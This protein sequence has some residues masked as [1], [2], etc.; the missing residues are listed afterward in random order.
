M[1]LI[2]AALLAG[3]LLAAIECVF[4]I[5]TCG[6]F[7]VGPILFF[8]TWA[9]YSAAALI[10]LLPLHLLL[11]GRRA[12]KDPDAGGRSTAVQV[13]LITLLGCAALL[14]LIRRDLTYG[15]AWIT[16]LVIMAVAGLVTAAA[17]WLINRGRAASVGRTVTLALV[18]MALLHLFHA[19]A[20]HQAGSALEARTA[21]YDGTVPHLCLSV[22]DTVRGDH[23]SCVGYPWETTP[24]MD[25]LA[26]EGLLCT[27]SYSAANYTPPGHISIFT[28]LYPSQHG[29]NGK[30]YAP[31]DLTTLT[32]ILAERGYFCVALYN[33]QLGGKIINLTQGFD[34]DLGIFKDSWVRPAWHRLKDRLVHKDA[35]ARTT[36]FISEKLYHWVTSR[37]GHLF[38]YLNL[39]E[40]HAGY[41]GHEP[42]FSEFLGDVSPDEIPELEELVSFVESVKEVVHDREIFDR[43]T[44]ASYDYM[45]AAYDSEIAYVDH[46]FGNFTDQLAEAGLL[47]DTLLVMT[48]DHAEFLG[49]YLTRGHPYLLLSHVLRIPLIIR[50]PALVEPAVID[51]VVSNV[52][53][54]PTVLELMG[55]GDMVG[56]AVQ[57]IDLLNDPTLQDRYILGEALDADQNCYTLFNGTHK[58]VF[59]DNDEL[60]E[61]F[62]HELLLFNMEDDP[63]ETRDLYAEQPELGQ[64]MLE[65]LQA[66][67]EAIK[68]ES[69]EEIEI[70]EV[71]TSFLE[72]LGYLEE[73]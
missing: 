50:Y 68:R 17:W 62:P 28:G 61:K 70:N 18:L 5:W 36:F 13:L 31:D 71:T 65:K 34:V 66:R 24:R 3:S 10:G 67:V 22:F 39:L 57:G 64:E 46:H 27:R 59:N 2:A 37:G 72:A 52:D 41:V 47:D 23:F 29:N 16:L 6:P 43:F 26:A 15:Q 32:E 4:I 63:R 7:W 48:A 49:E 8:Q 11:F 42:W 73:E 21:R 45:R 1:L 30:P 9:F 56:G 58:L 69:Q 12:R 40:P 54:F 60:L 55:Y 44:P 25:A 19:A 51:E 53:I 38:L 33:N 35:G 20:N 14:A